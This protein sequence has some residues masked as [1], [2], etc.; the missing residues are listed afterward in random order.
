ME[1]PIFAKMHVRI[2]PG[3]DALVGLVILLIQPCGH[4]VERR[5][6][7]RHCRTRALSTG[8]GTMGIGSRRGVRTASTLT[9]GN[10][11]SDASGHGGQKR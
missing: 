6:P 9:A 10:P 8:A 1:R 2:L 5:W 4:G 11:A 3:E 7:I